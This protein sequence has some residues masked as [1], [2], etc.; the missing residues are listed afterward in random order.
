MNRLADN[1]CYLAGAMEKDA[2][3]GIEWRQAIQAA[4]ADLHI[5]WLDPTNKPT[6]IG[7]ETLET[8]QELV[9]ARRARDYDAVRNIMKTIRCVDLRM[10][11][12]SDFSGREPGPRRAHLRD[13]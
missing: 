8:K 2:T 5:R 7:R 6:A 12:I 1:R 3:N 4:L 9:Q 11:D 10:T 13:T